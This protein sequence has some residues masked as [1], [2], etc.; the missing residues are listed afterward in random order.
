M[1]ER[2]VA[3]PP[4]VPMMTSGTPQLIPNAIGSRHGFV[5]WPAALMIGAGSQFRSN[6]RDPEDRDH[7]LDVV[8]A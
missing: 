6:E 7:P 4:A 5:T 1:I 3:N 2:P 8:V